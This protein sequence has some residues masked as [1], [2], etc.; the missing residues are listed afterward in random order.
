MR[1]RRTTPWI[2]ALVLFAGGA[3]VSFAATRYLGGTGEVTREAPTGCVDGIE[4]PNSRWR[5]V[6]LEWRQFT[7]DATGDRIW[8]PWIE[9]KARVDVRG[10]FD[11]PNGGGPVTITLLK[12]VEVCAAEAPVRRRSLF[13]SRPRPEPSPLQRRE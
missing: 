8:S 7:F 10:T 3:I 4:S 9:P 12:N 13:A 1:G 2:V 11:K 6:P 5:Q